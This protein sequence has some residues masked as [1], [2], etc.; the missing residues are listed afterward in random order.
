MNTKTYC[1]CIFIFSP[2]LCFL[3]LQVCSGVAFKPSTIQT[4]NRSG[5]YNVHGPFRYLFSVLRHER[6]KTRIFFSN[7]YFLRTIRILKKVLEC[8]F[9]VIC[10]L[11]SSSEEYPM[12][13][14]AD[15]LFEKAGQKKKVDKKNKA[16]FS[17]TRFKVQ[18]P[19]NFPKKT[20]LK[21]LICDNK[22]LKN[23]K[24]QLRNHYVQAFK[25]SRYLTSQIEFL[26]GGK[27]VFHF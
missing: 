2:F 11:P 1:Y 17:I 23:K 18:G 4:I 22:A 24:I 10:F 20:I 8:C 19:K 21:T 27:Q 3:N 12:L 14:K 26:S 16:V 6:G 7:V 9:F 25:N 13:K 5:I 15:Q